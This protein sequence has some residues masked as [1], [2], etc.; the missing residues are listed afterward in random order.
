M[1]Q[2]RRKTSL[3][4]LLAFHADLAFCW[5]TAPEKPLNKIFVVNKFLFASV[6]TSCSL[7]AVVKTAHAQDFDHV[8]ATHN[9][10]RQSQIVAPSVNAES[11]RA[12]FDAAYKS[13][14]SLPAGVLEAVAFTATRGQWLAAD[15]TSHSGIPVP[16]GVMA[17]HRGEGGFADLVGEAAKRTGLSRAVIENDLSANVLGAAAIIDGRMTKAQKADR[18]LESISN[19]LGALSGVQ[20][21]AKSEALDYALTSNAYDI[22]L[23]AD[24]GNDD[25]Q[26]KFNSTPVAFEKAFSIDHLKMLHAPM[27]RLDFT[28]KN[29]TPSVD[30]TSETLAGDGAQAKSTDY[31]PA[32]YVQS[33]NY[34]A[35]GNTIQFVAIHDTEGSYAGAIS[36]FTQTA[37]QVSAHYVI[38]SSDG[39]IT[40]MVRDSQKAWHVGVHNPYSLGIEHEGFAKQTGWYTSAMYTA[41]SKLTKNF[42]VRYAIDCTKTYKGASSSGVVPLTGYTVKGHQH[43]SSNS[44]SDPGINWDWPRY[45]GLINGATSTTRILDNFEASEGHFNTPPTY[46]GS[47]TGIATTST[48]DRSN[49][50]PKNG[51]YSERIVLNDNTA[52]SAAWAVRQLSGS[53]DPAQNTSMARAS[54]R[55][56]FWVYAS[57]GGVTVAAT[58]DDSDGTE[59]SISKSVPSNVWTFV[60]WNLDDAAQWNAWSGGNGTITSATTLDAIWFFH[61]GASTPITVYID[62]VQY[63]GP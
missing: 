18:T 11:L 59:R 34:S 8:V 57:T 39:Q 48:A 27:L 52:S 30:I 44:H 26:L 21:A 33:P 19:I 46:S 51:S 24:R 29:A 31:A 28:G 53:G 13:Y 63:T 50:R 7:L 55:V 54:G 22:L 25:G 32:L 6:L 62:D 1:L 42:C 41:S 40:Q 5:L 15:A 4:C 14:P 12:A 36:W 38:R 2:N 23:S 3:R 58:V 43:F 47:T 37:S 49:L 17:L 45:Y 10:D 35:R 56:G 20:N 61:A 16:V 9:S 60:Q